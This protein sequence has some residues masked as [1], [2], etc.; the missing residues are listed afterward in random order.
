MLLVLNDKWLEIWM[1]SNIINSV[2]RSMWWTLTSDVKGWNLCSFIVRKVCLCQS[3]CHTGHWWAD[4]QQSH[5]VCMVH[6]KGFITLPFNPE[7]DFV[8]NHSPI[9]VDCQWYHELGH[10]SL[11][12]K[13]EY[14]KGWRELLTSF[15][16]EFR[17]DV[18]KPLVLVIGTNSYHILVDESL[19]GF[20][21]WYCLS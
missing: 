15:C 8:I 6:V 13:F 17:Q 4:Q 2:H 3:W 10:I 11:V 16:I 19:D 21:Q 9:D 7:S 1:D 12:F 5:L 20:D 18:D 14:R